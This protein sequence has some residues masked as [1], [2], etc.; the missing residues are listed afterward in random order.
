MID[1][2]ACK[3][4][5]SWGISWGMGWR[6]L[7]MLLQPFADKYTAMLPHSPCDDCAELS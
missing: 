1:K 2:H 4:R 6:A 3:A 7:F 5:Y